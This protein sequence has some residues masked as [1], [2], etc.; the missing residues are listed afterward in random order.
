MIM[1][2]I[3]I[4][5]SLSALLLTTTAAAA[6]D[7]AGGDDIANQIVNQP[8]PG[9]FAVYGVPSPAKTFKDKTV[10]GG[11]ALRVVIPAASAQ[12]WTISLSDPI[13]KPVKKGDKLVL[14]FY[15]KV[16][17]GGTAHIANASVQLAKDPYT[18]VFGAPLD[19]GGEWKLYN[20]ANGVADQD[21]PAGALNV[22]L[23]LATGKQ[24]FD[25]GPIFVLD[26]GQS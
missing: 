26:L 4:A 9:A 8:P 11:T 22:S 25:F 5:I 24:T 14:A 18:G 17:G 13:V 19:V 21:Y 23:Q 1:K 20:V 16:E 15:A 2:P 10:Q 12:P 7:K 3:A 6:Q